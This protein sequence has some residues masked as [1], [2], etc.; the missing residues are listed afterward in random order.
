MGNDQIT[1]SAT[2]DLWGGKKDAR[3]HFPDPAMGSKS[4]SKLA[5]G[6][7]KTNKHAEILIETWM[8]ENKQNLHF[9]N[10]SQCIFCQSALSGEPWRVMPT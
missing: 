2:G 3:F 8:K 7:I 6:Q 1:L 4:S 5:T 10:S 9:F